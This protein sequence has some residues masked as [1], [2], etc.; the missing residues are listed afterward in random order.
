MC[1]HWLFGDN[2][3][4][5]FNNSAVDYFAPVATTSIVSEKSTT[6]ESKAHARFHT[7]STMIAAIRVLQ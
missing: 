1:R 5:P 7:Q 6:Y 3:I 4:Q 2:A